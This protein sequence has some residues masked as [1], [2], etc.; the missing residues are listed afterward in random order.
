[1]RISI[2]SSQTPQPERVARM[3]N[4]IAEKIAA[5]PNVSSVALTSSVTMD[6]M[7]SNDPIFAQDR[8][9]SENQ[10]PPLR[11]YKHITP[12]VF[13][14]M[15]NAVLAGRDITWVDI[16]EMR[17]VVLVSENLARELWGSPAA[18]VGKRVRESPK[19]VWREVVGVVA[20]EHDSG[21]HEKAPTVVYWPVMLRNLWGRDINIRRT[22]AIAIRSNR[23]G[24]SGFLQDVQRAI[25]SINPD[26]PVAEVRTVK[27]I[28]DRSMA[29]TSFTAVMLFIAAGTALLLGIVGIYGV[30]SYSISQRTR[31]IGIRMALGASQSSVRSLFV[32]HGL[33]LTCLGIACGFAAA[34][35]LT[36]LMTSLLY[37]TSPLDPATYGAVGV[38]LVCAA[39]VAAYL[40]ARRATR[41]EP[42]EALR[43]D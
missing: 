2:P 9:Y 18:A 24:S 35:P 5:V 23:T 20:N 32:R 25:W 16:H 38:V 17:P 4:D 14:T 37:G 7:N 27:D 21:V 40:P 39:I 6:G 34:I 28:Y 10:L 3:F 26:L 15:R 42:L 19:G 1:M 13:Q 8:T 33:M 43:F 29:R 11:R 41:I 36:R 31:E 30:I 22:M 12:G